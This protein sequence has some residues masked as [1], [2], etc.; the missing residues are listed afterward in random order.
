M[1]AQIDDDRIIGNVVCLAQLSDGVGISRIA[2]ARTSCAAI[3]NPFSLSFSLRACCAK[4]IP[5]IVHISLSVSFSLYLIVDRTSMKSSLVHMSNDAAPAMWRQ[6]VDAPSFVDP[7]C[8]MASSSTLVKIHYFLFWVVYTFINV[9]FGSISLRVSIKMQ[10][11]VSMSG[12]FLF[13]L[14]CAGDCSPGLYVPTFAY[15]FHYVLSV[16]FYSF[17]NVIVCA[18]SCERGV[19]RCRDTLHNVVCPLSTMA[20]A[21]AVNDDAVVIGVSIAVGVVMLLI[22]IASLICLTRFVE[23]KKNVIL[24]H[25]WQAENLLNFFLIWTSIACLCSASGARQATESWRQYCARR[26]R[27]TQR[28]H[29]RKRWWRNKDRLSWHIGRLMNKRKKTNSFSFWC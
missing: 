6:V 13:N 22:V 15:F 16:F 3:H 1:F 21:T 17:S 23:C 18:C 10:L 24:F 26:R 27:R 8:A 28:W 5:F 4:L 14:R 29:E 20:P 25:M 7:V 9:V 12:S 11:V 19:C 2:L